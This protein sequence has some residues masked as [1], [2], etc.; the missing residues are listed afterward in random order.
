ELV[1]PATTLVD[2]M[3]PAS[4]AA[5]DTPAIALLDRFAND[6]VHAVFIVDAAKRPLGVVTEADWLAIL[7]RGLA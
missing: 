1:S 2:A 5:P 6:R 3:T 4:T 7:R